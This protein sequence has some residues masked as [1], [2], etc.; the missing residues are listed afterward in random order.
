MS[1]ASTA[2]KMG[3]AALMLSAGILLSRLLGY[4][5]EAIIAYQQGA[6]METDAYNAAFLLPDL[7]NYFLAGG[8]LSITF[9]PLFSSFVAKDREADGWRLFSTIATVMGGILLAGIVLAEVF[10]PTLVPLLFP[11]FDG[12]ATAR[13]VELT[14]IV[15]PCQLFHYLGGLVLATLMAKGRFAAATLAPLVYNGC[16]VVFGLALG[17][18]MGMAGFAVGALVGSVLGP[19]GLSLFLARDIIRFRPSLAVRNASFAKYVLLTLPLMIGVSLM[20]VDEW[21][22]L[23]IKV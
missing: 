18:S 1:E 14:R 7:M 21:L 10:A 13:T 8:T 6:G 9:I 16:I 23:T 2:R 15:L 22:N 17:P 19:F 3:L 4:L 5:R 20:T 12:E 11:G